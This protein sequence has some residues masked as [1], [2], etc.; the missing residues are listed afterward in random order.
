MQQQAYFTYC[1]VRK[2]IM[3]ILNLLHSNL[4]LKFAGREIQHS[5][6]AISQIFSADGAAKISQSAP[7]I[8]SV[9]APVA[10]WWHI[11][12]ILLV[13]AADS[14]ASYYQHGL[15]NAH[16]PG[17]NARLSSYVTVVVEEWLLVLFIW[18]WLKRSGQTMASLTSGRWRS[19]RAFFRDV[20][21]A[22]GFLV[23]GIPLTSGLA[24]LIGV[25]SGPTDIL[26]R[27]ALEAVVWALCAV[28]AGF[29][30]E[31]IFRGYLMGQFTTRTKSRVLGIGLQG[32]VFGLAHGY[33]G[34]QMLVIFIY[35][36]M[37]GAFVTWRKSLLPAM[38]AHGVQDTVGGLANFF[39]A[40]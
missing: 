13:F 10:P 36:C 11:A 30:E 16:I 6:S 8:N 14:I 2:L 24:W 4:R 5:M 34:R 26:P 32:L 29:C 15:P 22:L 21:L 33:Q 25:R 19:A 18:L 27:T 20:G 23:V 31:L 12:V 38:I 37:F 17:L 40:R 35:G 1:V 28:T 9:A 3:T 7:P 39:L